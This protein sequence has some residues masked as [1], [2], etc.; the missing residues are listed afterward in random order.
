[1][2][3]TEN[4]K[5]A[6]RLREIVAAYDKDSLSPDHEMN[7]AMGLKA[8]IAV[9]SLIEPIAALEAMSPSESVLDSLEA[10]VEA[11]RAKS[12]GK[13]GPKTDEGFGKVSAYNFVLESIAT[14]KQRAKE[15]V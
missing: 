9:Q 12:Y 8:M 6:D 7:A 15:Q 10:E 11:M 13:D 5:L 3:A 4:K 14:A 1:M 2:S